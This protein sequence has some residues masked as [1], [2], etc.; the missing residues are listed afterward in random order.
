[1]SV[2]EKALLDP[3]SAFTS[4]EQ[5]LTSAELSRG[6]GIGREVLVRHDCEYS[7]SLS[8]VRERAQM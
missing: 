5:V 7:S 4:P 8:T 2:Y 3:T 1:M 6:A